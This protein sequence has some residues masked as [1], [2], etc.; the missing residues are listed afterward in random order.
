MAKLPF[1]A[2][3]STGDVFDFDFPLHSETVSAVRVGQMVSVLL[4]AIDRDIATAGAMS[5]GDL[6]Q[7]IAM[8]M[9]VRA[10]MV[11]A[12]WPT[13]G[14]L[15][16]NLTTVSIDAAAECDRQLLQHGHA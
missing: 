16:V 6:L 11:Y 9:A 14:R 8:T 10:R 1:R 2:R 15:A 12:P 5:D 3:T 7:A 4:G 13:A